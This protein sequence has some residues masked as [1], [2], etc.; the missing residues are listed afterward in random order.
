MRKGIIIVIL[1]AIS[2]ITFA[3]KHN[4]VNA[5]IALRN[6]NYAEAKQ[7]IDEA[8]ESESTAN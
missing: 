4:I 5:S 8:Y 3:Q 7:Y 2:T 6:E 1:V